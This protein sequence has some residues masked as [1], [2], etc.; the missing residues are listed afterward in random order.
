MT[1]DMVSRL[2]LAGT[3]CVCLLAAPAAAQRILDVR[4]QEIRDSLQAAGVATD[5]FDGVIRAGIGGEVL[6]Y[7]TGVYPAEAE[8]IAPRRTPPHTIRRIS[9]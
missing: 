1:T 4:C 5:P 3:L 8:R 2:K 7:N 6:L 9:R